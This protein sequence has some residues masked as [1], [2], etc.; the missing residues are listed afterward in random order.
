MLRVTSDLYP[1]EKPH[2]LEPPFLRIP[3][4]ESNK[5]QMDRLIFLKKSR[6]SGVCHRL[7]IREAVT[8]HV[9]GED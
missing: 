1:E 7:S 5:Y 8:G 3:L 4:I 6:M 2:Q 9:G